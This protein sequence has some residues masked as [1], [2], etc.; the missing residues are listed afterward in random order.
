MHLDFYFVR[1]YP[2]GQIIIDRLSKINL[3]L[4]KIKFNFGRW[5]N[6]IFVGYSIRGLLSNLFSCQLR[7]CLT[8]F[9]GFLHSITVLK[10]PLL[11]ILCL[12]KWL[13]SQNNNVMKTAISLKPLDLKMSLLW[14]SNHLLL[15]RRVQEGTHPGHV[16]TS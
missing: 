6:P 5:L 13:Y 16:Q 14:L 8:P 7:S 4:S 1:F 3:I 10:I 9:F 15:S 12:R 11:G 2:L